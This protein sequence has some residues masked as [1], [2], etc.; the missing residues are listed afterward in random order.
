MIMS[1]TNQWSNREVRNV[2]Q[3][4]RFCDLDVT[5]KRG[6]ASKKCGKRVPDDQ[7]ITFEINNK[8]YEVD[9]CEEHQADLMARL[10]PFIEI[11]KAVR[12]V[13]RTQRDG[14]GR[15]IHQGKAQK[16]TSKDVRVWLEEQGRD[17]SSSGRI[18]KT[19]IE[20]YEAAH[21]TK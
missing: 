11:G 6:S 10:E 5:S 13:P 19:L 12:V 9:L 7:P 2:E 4:Q 18:A 20:E 8:R 16:F 17:V 14:R 21:P 1:S 15:L 3:V